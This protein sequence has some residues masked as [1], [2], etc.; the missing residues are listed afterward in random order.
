MKNRK[1]AKSRVCVLAQLCKFIL[2]HLV[3]KLALTIDHGIYSEASIRAQKTQK[4]IGV[5]LLG[6]ARNLLFAWGA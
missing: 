3:P 6:I 2:G 4:T 5:E 1:P